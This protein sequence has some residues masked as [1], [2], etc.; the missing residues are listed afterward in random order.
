[1]SPDDSGAPARRR[2]R[3]EWLVP[4]V[5]ALV[6]LG[7][8]ASTVDNDFVCWD[9]GQNFLENSYYRGL[10]WSHLTWM[11]TTAHMGHYM[12]VTW[13]TLGLDYEIWGLD[14]AG[15]HLTSLLLHSAV[16]VAFYGVAGSLLGTALAGA[17]PWSL[18]LGAA[19]AALVFAVHPLRVESVAWA[20]ERRDV[21]CGLFYL[22]AVL[23]YL[24]Y[25]ERARARGWYVTS[26]LCAVLAVLSKSMAVSLCMILAIV[27]VYPLRRLGPGAGGW[28]GPAQRSV[29]AEKVPFLLVSL[30]A[31]IGAMLALRAS[32]SAP[33]SLAELSL[34]GRVAVA[35]YSVAFY[36]WKTIVPTGLSPLY[37]LPFRVRPFARSFVLAAVFAVVVS[38]IVVIER[39]RWPALAATWAAYLVVLLPVIGILHNGPQLVAD[40]YSYLSCL[41]WALLAGAALASIWPRAPITSVVVA[42]GVVG[43]LA[44]LTW[45]QVQIWRDSET[46]WTYAVRTSPSARGHVNLGVMYSEDRRDQEAMGEFL[47]AL[48]LRPTLAEAHAGLGV[49]RAR[50]GRVNEAI[51]SYEIAL[52][53]DPKLAE[54]HNDLGVALDR[55]GRVPEAVRQYEEAV[56]L[57]PGLE[58]AR[59]NLAK[60]Q[61]HAARLAEE[62]DRLRAELAQRPGDA[63]LHNGLGAALARRGEAAEAVAQ[64]QRA[65]ELDPRLAEAHYNWGSAL[66]QQGRL[67]EA[68]QQFRHALAVRPAFPEAR[69]NLDRVLEIQ[70]R[71]DSAR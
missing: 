50:Q 2:L 68:A 57:R 66:A 30:G 10:S 38:A 54:A 11:W 39:R 32:G 14:P 16:A 7:T 41:G 25:V 15:Y 6:T 69:R 27:D 13:L 29:W 43:V 22:G 17:A 28:L 58:E 65:L 71:S 21:L 23:A 56:R 47:A 44:S 19:F 1:M 34:P 31:S 9:D 67:D 36:V 63:T 20:T 5:V 55:Q 24:R 45:S 42:A 40:R 12:P 64:F 52:R 18:R 8:F 59:A 53:L 46:F 70:G 3:L 48:R 49:L 26:V 51:A 61:A 62:I 35:A 60:A 33:T 37:E 4:L